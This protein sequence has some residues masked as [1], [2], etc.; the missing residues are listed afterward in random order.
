MHTAEF[1]SIIAEGDVA[2]FMIPA[3]VPGGCGMAMGKFC[4]GSD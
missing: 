3:E 4:V 1:G 2:G